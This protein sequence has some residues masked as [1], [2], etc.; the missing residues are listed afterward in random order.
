MRCEDKYKKL[1]TFVRKSFFEEIRIN[2]FIC[3]LGLK[4]PLDRLI[5]Q[6]SQVNRIF[7]ILCLISSYLSVKKV[8]YFM[9]NQQSS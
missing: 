2:L 4:S 1:F 7:F 6:S 8:F 5:H 9:L 3:S